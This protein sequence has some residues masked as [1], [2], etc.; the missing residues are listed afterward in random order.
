MKLSDSSRCKLAAGFTLVELILVITLMGALLAYE[1]RKK[2]Q[3]NIDMTSSAAAKQMVEVN[4]AVAAY[5]TARYSQLSALNDASCLPLNTSPCYIEPAT[6]VTAQLLPAGWGN[7]NMWG[8]GYRIAVARTG[9]A[10]NWNLNAVTVTATPWLDGN[11]T[12]VFSALGK[13][14][15]EIGP[16]GGFSDDATTVRGL[17][18]NWTALV[19]D[20]D[21]ISQAGLLAAR[22][23]FRSTGQNQFLRLDGASVMTGNIN[24]G[25]SNLTN[26]NDITAIG[27]LTTAGNVSGNNATFTGSAQLATLSLTTVAAQGGACTSAGQMARTA[28]GG[29]VSCQGGAW[30]PVGPQG[31]PGTQGISGSDGQKGDKGVQGDAIVGSKGDMGIAGATGAQ[32]LEGVPADKDIDAANSKSLDVFEMSDA[33]FAA[34]NGNW[35]AVGAGE[36]PVAGC[37]AT[38]PCGFNCS[39]GKGGTDPAFSTPYNI[40]GSSVSLFYRYSASS[41]SN[42]LDVVYRTV[43]VPINTWRQMVAQ[44][45]QEYWPCAIDNSRCE[46]AALLHPS[47]LTGLPGVVSNAFLPTGGNGVWYPYVITWDYSAT[48]TSLVMVN[49]KIKI[50]PSAR[51]RNVSLSTRMVGYGTSFSVTALYRTSSTGVSDTGVNFTSLGSVIGAPAVVR[52][53]YLPYFMA[54][55]ADGNH[56]SLGYR[57]ASTA[58]SVEIPAGESAMLIIRVAAV[59]DNGNSHIYM[60]F[61]GWPQLI[62]K[63]LATAKAVALQEAKCIAKHSVPNCTPLSSQGQNWYPDGGEPAAG[64]DYAVLM[65]S[66]NMLTVFTQ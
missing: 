23:N 34:T 36:C 26:A 57:G 13:A 60:P 59:D 17:N 39:N 61:V 53:T 41:F 47:H 48:P 18:G 28:T 64:Q 52:K 66:V 43:S 32:G 29:I 27:N 40:A 56:G 51:K 54:C 4:N 8:S 44:G 35:D 16:D 65:P 42:P 2:V 45:D 58:C 62:G 3:D 22:V 19:T 50:E 7:T 30:S 38:Y 15:E 46:S 10:P 31:A 9:T 63:T 11:N 14:T 21:A 1:L 20:N 55:G 24:L 12:P 25:N 49:Y 5:I 33:L 6:L 37:I